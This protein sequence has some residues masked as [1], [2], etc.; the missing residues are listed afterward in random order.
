MLKNQKLKGQ[1]AEAKNLILIQLLGYRSAIAQPLFD[2]FSFSVFVDLCAFSR[3]QIL[4]INTASL[5]FVS[6]FDVT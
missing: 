3:H 2:C 4:N 5:L 1:R 6:F